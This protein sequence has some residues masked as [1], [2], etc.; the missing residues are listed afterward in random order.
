[1]PVLAPH[2]NT[3]QMQPQDPNKTHFY[4]SLVKSSLRFI[5]CYFLY[6]ERFGPAALFL[7]AAELLGIIEEI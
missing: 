6:C 7:A 1:M 2:Q 3:K 4:V 5:A